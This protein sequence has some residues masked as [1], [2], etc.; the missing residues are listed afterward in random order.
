[1]GTE[2]LGRF[3][4]SLLTV[5]HPAL[6]PQ[7]R[8][9]MSLSLADHHERPVPDAEEDAAVPEGAQQGTRSGGRCL[10]RAAGAEP[11]QGVGDGSSPW[12]VPGRG[13]GLRPG[14]W[15]GDLR[16]PPAPQG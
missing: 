4:H 16:L 10:C 9:T 6:S 13:Q 3:I 1:M 12:R 7:G 11:T 2:V 5:S 15:H 14:W 8:V